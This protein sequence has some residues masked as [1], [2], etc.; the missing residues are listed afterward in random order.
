MTLKKILALLSG[1]VLFILLL[2]MPLPTGMTPE[3]RAILASTCWVAVWWITEAIP[4]PVTSLLPII[5]FPLSG[6]LNIKATTLGYGHPILFLFIGGFIIAIA[7]EKWG[8]HKR[9]ALWIISK[10]GVNLKMIVLGFM[11]ATAFLSMW[12]SNTAATLLMLPI[13][14]AVIYHLFEK[15]KEIPSKEKF[16]RVLMLSI[17]YAASIGGMATLIGTPT[18]I[19]LSGLVREI[20]QIEITFANWILIGLP[21]SLILLFVCWFY[22]TRFRFKNIHVQIQEGKESLKRQFMDLGHMSY[23]ETVVAVVFGITAL[24]WIVRPF[25][26]KNL[27]P[28][29]DDNIIALAGAMAL[30]IIPSRKN[31]GRQILDWDAAR[32]LPWGIILLFGGGLA[33]AAGFR[34]SGLAEWFGLQ[35]S[36]FEVLPFILVLAIV[37]LMINFLTEITSNMATASVILPIL[38]TISLQSNLHPIILM[39]GATLA[40]SCAFMLPV[41]TPPNAIV[42]STGYLRITDMAKTGFV[43]NLVS[44][45]LVAGYLYLISDWIV[46][47]LV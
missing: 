12:I 30:F 38:A 3:A 32:K 42:F 21:L 47:Y 8:L 17:A 39:I 43:M 5:L 46:R 2:G 33:I 34:D 28:G 11:L 7:I 6:G 4:I 9:M 23:E 41:A 13:S 29:L 14:T 10:I 25:L 37:V 35:M 44:I 27:L 18:N 24:M 22:L 26:L 16:G 1:P 15:G 36:V 31:K 19:I 20:F 40:A 45:I